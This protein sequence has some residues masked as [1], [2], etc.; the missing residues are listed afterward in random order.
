MEAAKRFYF[1]PEYQVLVKLRQSCTT[2]T[3]AIIEGAP[4]AG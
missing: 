4:P 3:A 1:S 2:G